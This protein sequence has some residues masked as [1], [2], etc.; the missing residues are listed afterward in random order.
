MDRDRLI[1]V[2]GIIALLGAA[3]GTV[4]ILMPWKTK[5]EFNAGDPLYGQLMALLAA[6]EQQYGIPTDL[7]ARQAYEE[8]SFL[9]SNIYG[10][11]NA[12]GAV[13][14]MQFEPA[15]AA[16]YGVTNLDDPSQEIP[17]AAAYMAALYKE[18]GSWGL[19]LAAYDAGPGNVTKYGGMPPFPETQNYVAQILAD[20]NAEGQSVQ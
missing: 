17:A 13:G 10:G 14:L 16:Q 6:A 8:S 19:A 20:V 9:P 2:I 18:F 5:A 11:A 4:Y 3:A 12:A 1:T 15:T 7:L